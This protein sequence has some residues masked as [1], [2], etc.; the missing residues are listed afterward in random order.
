M[1]TGL[2]PFVDGVMPA[3]FSIVLLAVGAG[4]VMIALLV[5]MRPGIDNAE[6]STE[7]NGDARTGAAL[8]LYLS[9]VILLN[10]VYPMVSPAMAAV[11]VGG[12]PLTLVVLASS[13]TVPWLAQAACLPAYRVIGDLMA[14][15]DLE[16]ITRR[17]CQFWPM[18]FVQS[19]PLV[20][21][22]ALPL[23]LVTGWTPTA[24][25]IFAS[26]CG[27]HLLFV[28]SLVM[29]N[30]A[31]R[32]GAWALA[33]SAYAGALFLAPTLWWLPP[34]IG[35]LTQLAAMGPGLRHLGVA[36]RIGAREFSADVLRGLLMGS[37]LWAD[38][39]VLFLAT[40]GDFQ[41]VVVFA[42]MLPAVVAY[43][44]Y[45]INLAPRVDREMAGLHR[46]ISGGPMATL[47][48]A[49]KRL[50]LVVDRSVLTTGTIGVLL[51]LAVSL[52]VNGLLPT[53]VLLAV[54]AG[55]SSW[56]FMMLT[57][58]SY[59]LDFIGEKVSPQFLGGA[60]LVL[61]VAAFYVLG[62]PGGD[63]NGAG[64]YAALVVADLLLVG[65][66]WLLYKRHWVQPEYTLFWRH[67][68]TW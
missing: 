15:R 17:F 44:F 63:G 48:T 18:M 35:S 6:E 39:L 1:L 38:K 25:A 4:V 42:A 45:F 30:V 21:V 47:L 19:L 16:A 68:T 50:S 13:I 20:V 26:L 27:L 8:L 67:A 65:V 2:V 57:L 23:W 51:T 40:G 9:P 28:Q 5:M 37:V 7:T 58:L 22:F 52:V 31:N 10:V 34:L 33:W 62:V 46:T 56:A 41:V 11:D 43:N 59:E 12:V 64:A 53:Q 60:H 36:H 3:G 55:A 54:F 49:S 29:S 61:C 32:R 24:L 14:E 66:A